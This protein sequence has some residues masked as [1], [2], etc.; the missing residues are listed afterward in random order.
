MHVCGQGIQC[1]AFEEEAHVLVTGGPDCCVRVW[2]SF[3]ST[4]PSALLQGHRAGII[5]LVL[6]DRARRAYSLARDRTIKVW[7][8]QAQACLQVKVLSKTDRPIPL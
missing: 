6:Q 1:F 4:A 3:V 8:L 5:A 7:D 2:N